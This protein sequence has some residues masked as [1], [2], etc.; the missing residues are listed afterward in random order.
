[1]REQILYLDRD[2]DDCEITGK[3]VQTDHAVYFVGTSE[4]NQP[5]IGVHVDGYDICGTVAFHFDKS[6]LKAAKLL[7]KEIKRGIKIRE[8]NDA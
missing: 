3:T 2:G 7:V 1:M 6:S 4:M 5:V 8:N